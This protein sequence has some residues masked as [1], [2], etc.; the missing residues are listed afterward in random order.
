MRE[1]VLTT[2]TSAYDSGLLNH[3]LPRFEA[4]FN[5]HVN[6]ISVGSGL[7]IE[8]AKQGKSDVLLVHDPQSEQ[9][10]INEGLGVNRRLVMHNDFILVG[11]PEDSAHISD[12]VT[13]VEAFRKLAKAKALFISRDDASGTDKREK[14]IWDSANIDRNT[15]NIQSTTGGMAKALTMASS[16]GG[17]LL[18]DRATYLAKKPELKQRVIFEGDELLLNIYHVIQVNPEK[19][20]D[21]NVEGAIAFINF[22][23]GEGQDIIANFMENKQ[24]NSPFIPDGG[25][26]L[27][28]ILKTQD[29][30]AFI[31]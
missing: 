17:Y 28:E 15:V 4:R 3:L 12:C 20:P 2:T 24:E 16:K 11:P 31:Y 25:R 10:F 6:V 23:L 30:L 22:L 1:L 29:Q 19:I 21:I 9:Q 5:Y 8:L 26:D 13:I 14:L 7:A 18:T 27:N